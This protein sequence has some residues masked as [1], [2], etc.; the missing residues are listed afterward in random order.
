MSLNALVF[1]LS[2]AALYLAHRLFASA[3][4]RLQDDI[5]RA[6]KRRREAI[7]G[8][9]V[10]DDWDGECALKP[11]QL[12]RS[13]NRPSFLRCRTCASTLPPQTVAPGGIR[14][15]VSRAEVRVT[16]ETETSR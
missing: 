7:E 15:H 5:E 10:P 14:A 11:C 2:L 13:L 16:R 8:G 4:D 9:L 3:D 1:A 12:C 6:R